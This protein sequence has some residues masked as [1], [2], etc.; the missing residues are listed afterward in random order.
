MYAWAGIV[1]LG[2]MPWSSRVEV[3]VQVAMQGCLPRQI[4][5][6]RMSYVSWVDATVITAIVLD[7][8]RL[9]SVSYQGMEY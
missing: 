8:E 6:L 9:V 5:L 2:Y 7:V 1:C 4:L 3:R